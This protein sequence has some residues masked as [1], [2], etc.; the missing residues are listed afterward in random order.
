MAIN[1]ISAYS[2]VSETISALTSSYQ[3]MK[4]KKAELKNLF[5]G[6]FAIMGGTSREAE[7]IYNE[8]EELKTLIQELQDQINDWNRIILQNTDAIGNNKRQM[9]SIIE[10]YINESNA[11]TA[12]AKVEFKVITTDVLDKF[13]R[14]EISQE[15]VTSRIMDRTAQIRTTIDFP[16]DKLAEFRGRIESSVRIMTDLITQQNAANLKV[17]TAMGA[18]SLLNEMYQMQILAKG[19]SVDEKAGGKPVYTQEKE[20]LVEQFYAQY[21]S[22]RTP[23][24]DQNSIANKQIQNLGAALGIGPAIISEADYDLGVTGT[25]VYTKSAELYDREDRSNLYPGSVLQEMY[26]AGFSYKEAMYACEYIFEGDGNWLNYDSATDGLSICWGHTANFSTRT[27]EGSTWKRGDNQLSDAR[28]ITD[29]FMNQAQS[30]WGTAPEHGDDPEP[31]TPTPT[32]STTRTDPIGWSV[33]NVTY[34]F[35]VDRNNDGTFNGA[36]EFLGAGNVNGKTGI[37]QLR[38]LDKNGDNKVDADELAAGNVYLLR[39]NQNVQGFGYL[40]AKDAGIDYIDLSTIDEVEAGQH[41]NVN[42]KTVQHTFGITFKDNTQ[43]VGYQSLDDND[44]LSAVYGDR[45]AKAMIGKI[46]K[47]ANKKAF[48]L[49]EGVE[50]LDESQKEKLSAEATAIFAEA[51]QKRN[52]AI[53]AAKEEEREMVHEFRD[54]ARNSAAGAN[55]TEEDNDKD[56]SVSITRTDVRLAELRK[57]KAAIE[58]QLENM[59]NK[60]LE[61]A[62]TAL[63]N[64]LEARL[65]VVNAEIE[66]LSK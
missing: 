2:N 32:T 33:G 26:N 48:D 45:Y 53:N 16:E 36:N 44:Y 52:D 58:V 23:N 55:T 49:L 13:A 57:T 12:K 10:D 41:A 14:G 47:A 30:L 61:G 31:T 7:T 66:A 60:D 24:V 65:I 62:E 11:V 1:D 43:V 20:A 39:N 21:H 5:E 46:D 51:N 18:L 6:S 15:D 25:S 3:N 29:S 34:D 22:A 42:G 17:S 38:A 28:I 37:D 64:T 63:K 56:S 4:T 50:L 9:D 54:I 40:T 19:S 59:Y 8:M 35:V 27:Q